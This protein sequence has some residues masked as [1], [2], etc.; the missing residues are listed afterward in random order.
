MT[1]APYDIRPL[2]P[3]MLPDFLAFFE[4]DAFADNP[5]WGFC[6]CQFLHVDH[7]VV[8]WSQRTAEQNRSAA[9][10]RICARRMQGYLAYVDG[11]PIAW[12][13]ATPRTLME[14]FA[15]ESGPDD[16]VTGQLGCFVV[17]K[18]YRR[19]GIASAL[20]QA[21][22]HGFRQQGLRVAK[23]MPYEN[24]QTDAQ[25]HFGP[26]RMFV[27]AGFERLGTDAQGRV[28]MQCRL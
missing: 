26:L 23:A 21:A 13:N 17:A 25:H 22:L 19:S 5:D 10:D 7:G 12:C 2:E 14:A 4:G 16:A 6:F 9:R 28:L 1:A 18:P 24:A 8:Q 15:D 3:A 20:L 27:A 11:K